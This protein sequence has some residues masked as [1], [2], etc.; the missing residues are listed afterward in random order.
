M[1]PED[2]IKWAKKKI[3]EEY[4]SRKGTLARSIKEEDLIPMFLS[5]QDEKHM[6]LLFSTPLERPDLIFGVTI[7]FDEKDENVGQINVY[8]KQQVFNYKPEECV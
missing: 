1:N 4:N 5:V 6:K 7:H 2:T 3:C 8:R